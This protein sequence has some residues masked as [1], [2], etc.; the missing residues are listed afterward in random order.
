MENTEILQYNL[1][2][3]SIELQIQDEVLHKLWLSIQREI[4][5]TTF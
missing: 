2:F 5:R 1:K 4:S 3:S